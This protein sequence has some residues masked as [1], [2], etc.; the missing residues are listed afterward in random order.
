MGD[1]GK[2]AYRFVDWLDKAGQSLWQM[3]PLGPTG[4]GDSPYASFST[5][6]GNPNLIA[7]EPLLRDG[8]L[9]KQDLRALRKLN[10]DHIDYGQ[11]IPLKQRALAIAAK[12]FLK[13]S[14]QSKN[15][16]FAQF[17]KAEAWWLNDYALFMS[18]KNSQDIIASENN[19]EGA[20]WSTFWPKKLALRE[21]KALFDWEESNK[22][23]I[24]L[25]KV[26]QYFFFSQWLALKKYANDKGIS[27]VGDLPIFVANDSVDVWSHR[28][29]FQLDAA[30]QPVAVAGVPPDYFSATGQLWGNPLYDWPKH[31][32]NGFSWWIQRIKS[33]LV[34]FDYLRIDHFRGF[35][36]FWSIPFGNK[37]AVVGSWEKA[38]GQEF[39][40][41]L[42]SQLPSLPILAEDL[43][44]ITDEVRKLRDSFSLPGMRIL[45]FAF[46]A[47]E[48]GKGLDVENSFLPHMYTKN[49]IVYTGTHDN[50]TLLSWIQKAK[51]KELD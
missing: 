50:D 7:L 18:I 46:D 12:A 37:N 1:L 5:F 29:L 4:Y 47:K 20:I 36:S 44:F 34:L 31:Q 3:L 27:I 51:K 9:S 42:K 24:E 15:K 43:G 6:A 48:S 13:N 19:I 26:I 32:E 39:F 22:L 11:I 25:I 8:Y 38:P 10:A 28:E 23:N 49:S 21:K 40:S 14:T 33:N 17:K 2:E 35:E 30:G 41:K 45:Q 16:S